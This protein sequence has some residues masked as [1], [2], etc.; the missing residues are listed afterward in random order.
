VIRGN[1]SFIAVGDTIIEAYDRVVV[2]AKSSAVKEV[3]A[4]F[5]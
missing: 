1:D 3:D 2:F 4:F 5:K